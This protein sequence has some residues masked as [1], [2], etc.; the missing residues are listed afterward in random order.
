MLHVNF[1]AEL[2]FFGVAV[3]K[4]KGDFFQPRRTVLNRMKY[5]FSYFYFFSYGRLDLQ[6]TGDT[7]EFTSVTPN[8]KK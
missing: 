8:Q 6:F 5:Q 4:T 7:P 1:A 3:K 2:N